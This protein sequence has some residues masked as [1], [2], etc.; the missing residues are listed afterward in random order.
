MIL[1][2]EEEN[3]KNCLSKVANFVDEIIVVDTGSND[4]TKIIASEF[5]DKIYDFK[6]CND[7]S[8]A[9]NFSISKATNDWII[10]LDADEFII[11]F[12]KNSV[13]EFIR[14]LSNKNKVGRIQRINI[15]E[16]LSGNKKY[17]ERVNRLFNRHYFH[18]EGI[19]HE[20]IV[21][22]DGKTYETENEASSV[23]LPSQCYLLS[24]ALCR[25]IKINI[26]LF[27]NDYMNIKRI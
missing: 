10:I 21:A 17:V 18:Y 1:K 4:N 26:L 6:W 16:D 25:K 15:M 7:F 13:Y 27:E 19:I 22:L 12:N 8:K 9:R 23:I 5:T 2:N 11:N 3:L 14:N 24:G 20:Q